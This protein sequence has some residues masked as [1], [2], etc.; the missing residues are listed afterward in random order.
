VTRSALD[1]TAFDEAIKVY[2][3]TFLA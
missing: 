3:E 2:R 1:E